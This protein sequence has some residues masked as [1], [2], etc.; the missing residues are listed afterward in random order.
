MR[1]RRRVAGLA[2]AALAGLVLTGSA[3]AAADGPTPIPA[4]EV[5]TR[6]LSTAV[7]WGTFGLDTPHWNALNY[8]GARLEADPSWGRYQV[9][10]RGDDGDFTVQ[11]ALA[12]LDVRLTIVCAPTGPHSTWVSVIAT[13]S[14]S[15]WAEQERNHIRAAIIALRLN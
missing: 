5:G 4:S 14:N 2:A 10:D 12:P 8:I 15:S 1:L 3:Q 11:G 13:S 7:H 9:Y 6:S